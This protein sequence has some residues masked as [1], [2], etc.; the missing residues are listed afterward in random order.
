MELLWLQVRFGCKLGEYLVTDSLHILMLLGLLSLSILHLKEILP[1]L[2][3][4]IV[5]FFFLE[6]G[7]IHELITL[8]LWR[9]RY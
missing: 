8:S 6:I 4:D 1:L 2:L 9:F 7:S 3:A 5:F